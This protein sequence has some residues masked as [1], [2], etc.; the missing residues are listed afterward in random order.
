MTIEQ[1]VVWGCRAPESIIPGPDKGLNKFE[2]FSRGFKPSS[3]QNVHASAGDGFLFTR[4][5][6]WRLNIKNGEV[7]EKYLTGT[8]FSLEFPMINN[9]F[10]G[11]K[12]SFGYTQ[13]VDSI[14]SSTSG[15]N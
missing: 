11:L 14:A 1:V 4:L 3:G 12:N 6:E 15:N 2:W 13:V 8:E 9:N 7:R 5:Y 10:T